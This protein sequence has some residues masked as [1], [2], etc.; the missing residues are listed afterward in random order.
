MEKTIVHCLILKCRYNIQSICSRNII[1]IKAMEDT[2]FLSCPV[3]YDKCE[4]YIK[5]IDLDEQEC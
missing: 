2:P 3:C 4:N 1:L 5:T